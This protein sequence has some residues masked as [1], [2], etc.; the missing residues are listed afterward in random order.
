MNSL[1]NSLTNF[2]FVVTGSPELLVFWLTKIGAAIGI[3]L[4]FVLLRNFFTRHILH[5]LLKLAG[6]TKNKLDNYLIM[7]FEA[8]LKLFFIALGIYL[9][10]IFLPLSPE[11]NFWLARF[12]RTLLVILVSLGLGNLA[13]NNEVF[14]QEL[15]GLT[16]I[17]I[18]RLLIPFLSKAMKL[19]IALLA[20]SIILQEWDYDITGIIAGLG[21]GGLAFALAAQETAANLFGGIV[22][23][24]DKPFSIGDWILTP[25]VEGTVED[26]NFR[27]TRIRTFAQAVVTVP[28]SKLANEPIT[29]WSR[30]GKR[31]I[32]FKLS[33]ANITSQE[34]LQKCITDIKKLLVSHPGI[35]QETILVSFDSFGENSLNIFLYFFTKT[36]IWAEFLQV[37]EDVNFRILDILDAEGINLAFPRTSLYVENKNG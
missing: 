28:N 22:I 25:S 19:I 9:A 5:Y 29:N 30:M 37:K 26:I 11:V 34:K 15:S 32:T 2:I 6:K 18:D 31:Q 20:I 24:T 4:G 1:V 23:I 27:S 17:K 10:L 36:T 14:A 3:L 12:F 13:G 21:L 16:G 35:H 8:P 33:V 7:A